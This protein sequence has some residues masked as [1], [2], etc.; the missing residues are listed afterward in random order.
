MTPGVGK[1][2]AVGETELAPDPEAVLVADALGLV[3]GV[4]GIGFTPPGQS[5]DEVSAFQ[6]GWHPG[7]IDALSPLSLAAI[8]NVIPSIPT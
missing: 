6:V 5:Q 7:G 3:G 1:G 8:T 4:E 2:A